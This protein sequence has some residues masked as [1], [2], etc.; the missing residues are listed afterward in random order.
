MLG[1][2]RADDAGGWR[3]HPEAGGERHAQRVL[4]RVRDDRDLGP[5]DVLGRDAVEVRLALVHGLH[6]PPQRHVREAD[7][8]GV[9]LGCL[10]QAADH[11]PPDPRPGAR[12]LVAFLATPHDVGI[13]AGAADVLADDVQQQHVDGLERQAGHRGPRHGE[14]LRLSCLDAVRRDGLDPAQAGMPVLDQRDAEAHGRAGDRVAGDRRDE[15]GELVVALPV[16]RVRALLLA[17]ADGEHLHE[18]ALHGPREASVGLDAVHGDDEVGALEC[19]AIDE[20][21]DAGQDLAEVDRLHRRSDLAAHRLGRDAVAGEHLELAGRGR[22]AMAAHGRDDEDLGAR[23][24]QAVHDRLHDDVDAVD[25]AASRGH[26]GAGPGPHRAHHRPEGRAGRRRDVVQLSRVEA[27]A[28]EGPAR[29]GGRTE[30][31]VGDTGHAQIMPC[32]GC[33]CRASAIGPIA[34]G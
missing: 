19:V 7:P 14:E 3:L 9:A 20:D 33:A 13:H 5:L 18:P 30:L 24:A 12:L 11:D 1:A 26:A 29:E 34:D 32:C 6:G 31:G 23:L 27:L 22:A 8:R 2:Q 10:G 28:D 17:Q 4:V 25:A 21:G 15:A 16:E